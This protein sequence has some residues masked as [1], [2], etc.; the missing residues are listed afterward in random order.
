M[1]KKKAAFVN[2]TVKSGI[3]K[4]YITYV[5]I[6]VYTPKSRINAYIRTGTPLKSGA[7][8][9]KY[10]ITYKKLPKYTSVSI[11]G[12]L[13]KYFYINVKKTD[14]KGF[15]KKSD[16]VYIECSPKF[17]TARK[18]TTRQIDVI[19]HNNGVS[20]LKWVTDKNRV[21]KKGKYTKKG[22]KKL[23]YTTKR[24]YNIKSKT[25][26][27]GYKT[28]KKRSATDKLFISSY[29]ATEKIQGFITIKQSNKYNYVKLWKVTKRLKLL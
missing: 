2:T 16:V 29:T 8:D 26:Y 27:A 11:I 18:N 24:T 3:N 25:E 7:S 12:T 4:D 13:G 23:P 15:V 6:S 10:A 1:H 28:V 9:G 20:G 22:K 5:P 14:T 21:F 17:R 19:V